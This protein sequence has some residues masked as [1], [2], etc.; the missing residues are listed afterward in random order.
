M[1]KLENIH[2]VDFIRC[3]IAMVICVLIVSLTFIGI[4]NGLLGRKTET[5]PLVGAQIFRYFTVLSSLLIHTCAILCIPFEVE[6]LLKHNYHL[7]RWIV[8]LLYVGV[9]CTTVTF[10]TC[11]F[12]VAPTQGVY[13]ILFSKDSIFLHFLCPILSLVLFLVINVDHKI[14]KSRVIVAATPAL[15]YMV[16]Y[17]IEVFVV[18]KENGGWVDH[19]FVEG[20]IGIWLLMIVLT[21]ASLT[22]AF[23]LRMIH[24]SGH[25]RY[26]KLL[27][28]YY[29]ESGEYD[30][31]TITEAIRHLAQHDRAGYKGGAIGIPVHI[32]RLL[33][34]K[35]QP[36][37]SDEELYRIYL[38]AFLE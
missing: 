29:T 13:G 8:D 16:I 37:A 27:K 4:I 3:L 15:V 36:A 12:V 33:K 30:L 35:Y 24:N 2:T 34:E 17:Y 31:S 18:T 22:V 7:P 21:A 19:Y 26:K 25:T 38:E 10:L 5:N 32:I 9:T 20:R 23:L 14:R 6:G 1:K 28:H 11:S